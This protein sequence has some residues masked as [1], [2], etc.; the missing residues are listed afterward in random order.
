MALHE[1]PPNTI[2]ADTSGLYALLDRGDRNHQAALQFY[3]SL[4][5]GT[6]LIVLEYVLVELM[7]LLRRRGFTQQAIAFR[8]ALNQSDIFRLLY[9]SEHI[10]RATFDVYRQYVD[11]DWSYTD[12]AILAVSQRLNHVPVFSFDHHITQMGLKRV[13]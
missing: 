8:D 2:I 10:E 12:C 5:R 13:P 9:S 4:S 6:R 7:T 1:I 11:K 3:D